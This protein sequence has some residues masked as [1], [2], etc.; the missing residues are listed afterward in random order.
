MQF[1]D[2]KFKHFQ[3]EFGHFGEI[4]FW[5]KCLK[6]DLPQ[7]HDVETRMLRAGRKIVGSFQMSSSEALEKQSQSRFT[8]TLGRWLCYFLSRFNFTKI[9]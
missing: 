3:I 7:L 2:F 8:H 5:L 9:R 6:K 4:E 1:L